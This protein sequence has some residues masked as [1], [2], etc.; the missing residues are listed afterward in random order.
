MK[1]KYADVNFTHL[2]GRELVK[3]LLD[4][5]G[6]SMSKSEIADY[7]GVSRNTLD[8][9]AF[10]IFHNPQARRVKYKTYSVAQ[11]L[12]SCSTLGNYR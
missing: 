10:G 6:D 9:S 12:D 3:Y 4:R 1:A 11:W 7:A 8:T 2:R 5:Y